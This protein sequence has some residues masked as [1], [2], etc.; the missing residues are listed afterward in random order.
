MI[1]FQAII[2]IIG[3]II[4]WILSGSNSLITGIFQSISAGTFF[5][6]STF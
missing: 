4:G 1:Y 5:Y 2:N 6:I 3:L